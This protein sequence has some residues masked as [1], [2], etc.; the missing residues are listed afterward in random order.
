MSEAVFGKLS[1]KEYSSTA[2]PR[3]ARIEGLGEEIMVLRHRK[4]DFD[5]DEFLSRPLM[6]HLATTAE[7]GACES[8]LWYVWEDQAVWLLAE[9]GYNSFQERIQRDGRCAIGFVD[10]SPS[11]GRIQHLGMRGIARSEPWDD[12]RAMRFLR[13]YYRAYLGYREPPTR[14][15]DVPITGRFPMIW[16]RFDPETMV[17]KDQSFALSDTDSLKG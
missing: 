7:S 8:P 5:M 17:L 16:V 1:S 3:R 15:G 14:P 11:T 10:F 4:A 12:A 6:A 2:L 9:V 13:R